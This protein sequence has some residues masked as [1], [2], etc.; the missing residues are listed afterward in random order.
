MTKW[1]EYEDVCRLCV[2][3]RTSSGKKKYR[4]AGVLP[5][6]TTPHSTTKMIW[7]H[8]LSVTTLCFYFLWIII[9]NSCVWIKIS[10]THHIL[11]S[12]TQTLINRG[13]TT[14]NFMCTILLYTAVDIRSAVWIRTS[15]MCVLASLALDSCRIRSPKTS[16]AK[17]NRQ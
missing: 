4:Y 10:T 6:P 2:S 3:S 14:T 13:H 9:K 12:I 1:F 7:Y 11:K 16:L 15:E 5:S 8:S 17:N